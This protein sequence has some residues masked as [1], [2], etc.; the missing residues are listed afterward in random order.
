MKK[1]IVILLV[2]LFSSLL[3]G[4]TSS[5]DIFID[6]FKN[7]V[8]QEQEGNYGKAIE[9][10]ARLYDD[11]QNNYIVN[12]RL[13]WLYYLSKDY[14]NSLKYYN[15][16]SVISNSSTESLLGLIYPYYAMGKLDIVEELYEKILNKDEFNYTANLK[17]GQIYLNRTDYIAAKVHLEKLFDDYPSDYSVNFYLAW[18]YYYL[19][20]TSK[21]NE[22]FIISLIALPNDANALEGYNLTK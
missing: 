12:L 8:A 17:L 11:F 13:G 6:H 5:T 14:K 10:I 4:Q 21:A 20:N 2:F 19:G 7:S 1:L 15:E 9:F 18:S 3:N 22:L 16:A